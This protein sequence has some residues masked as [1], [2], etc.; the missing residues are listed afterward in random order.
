M[1]HLFLHNCSRDGRLHVQTFANELRG[2]MNEDREAAGVM[3]FEKLV[4]GGREPVLAVDKLR[5]SLI[6]L[7]A[8]QKFFKKTSSLEIKENWDYTVELFVCLN[9]LARKKNEL[10]MDDFLYFLDNF[11]MYLESTN[12]FK[13]FLDS[14]FR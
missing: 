6:P 14:C 8:S 3:L 4:S 9:L 2:Q 7:K 13:E 11:S 12:D 1:K 10:D 5:G